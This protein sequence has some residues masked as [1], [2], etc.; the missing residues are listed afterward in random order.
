[1]NCGL[2]ILKYF[3]LEKHKTSK[4]Q[5]LSQNAGSSSIRPLSLPRARRSKCDKLVH[6]VPWK[7]QFGGITAYFITVI[8]IVF[9]YF[10]VVI[11]YCYVVQAGLKLTILLPQP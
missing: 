8:L 1:M 10:V 7:G 4:F 11:Q 5:G 2:F 6:Q 9:C 3:E